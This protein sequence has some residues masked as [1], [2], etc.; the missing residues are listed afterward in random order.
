MAPSSRA[1]AQEES[2][3]QALIIPVSSSSLTRRSAPACTRSACPGQYGS[4]PRHIKGLAGAESRG[5]AVVPAGTRRARRVPRVPVPRAPE[6]VGVHAVVV[7]Q[8]VVLC[9]RPSRCEHGFDDQI[10]DLFLAEVARAVIIRPGAAASSRGTARPG[11]AAS[12]GATATASACP[13]AAAVTRRAAVPGKP[14]R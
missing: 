8:I 12:S 9:A 6:A 1:V 3:R 7:A 4:R 11:A 5:A 14:R 2:R 13:A 10:Q